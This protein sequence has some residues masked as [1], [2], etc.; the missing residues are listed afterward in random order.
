MLYAPYP[1]SLSHCTT[2]WLCLPLSW[3]W[4]GGA[5][6]SGDR[7]ITIGASWCFVFQRL[8]VT[9]KPEADV[10]WLIE[11]FEDRELF[12]FQS[13]TRD[14]ELVHCVHAMYRV[15]FGPG[16]VVTAK[17]PHGGA[18]LHVIVSGHCT[19]A[20]AEAG[21]RVL[22]RGDCVGDVSFAT[23]A[24]PTAQVADGDEGLVTYCL[25]R[26]TYRRILVPRLR[27]SERS[28]FLMVC[29]TVQGPCP[30]STLLQPLCS[31]GGHKEQG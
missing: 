17:A 22:Q 8:Q 10:R 20:D 9:P 13:R 5:P 18:A 23:E 21:P 12:G 11:L 1:P 7:P 25:E 27:R 31:R 4:E 19:V 24:P 28:P 26:E 29:H 3:G 14:F 6:L 15:R 16:D 2:L 30:P